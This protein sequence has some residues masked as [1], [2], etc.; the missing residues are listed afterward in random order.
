MKLPNVVTTLA[1]ACKTSGGTAWVV[2]GQVRDSLIGLDS[3]DIDIEVHGIE[4]EA[5]HEL[6]AKLGPVNE[7][8]KSFGVFKV[9]IE[10]VPMDVSIPRRDSQVGLR[11][12][13]VSVSGDPHMGIEE[14]ARRR[15][16]T[17]NAIAYDP[18]TGEYADPY[19]GIH[20][21]ERGR[22]TA[23]DPSTFMEDPLRALRVVQFAARFGFSIHEDLM[24]LCRSTRLTTLPA[25]RIWGEIEKLLMRSPAPSIG[26]EA[27]MHTGTLAQVLPE[28]AG[29][30]REVVEAALDRAA[31]LRADLDEPGRATALMVAALLHR[32]TAKAAVASLDRLKLYRLHDYPVRTRVLEAIEHWRALAGKRTDP[33]ILALA[34]QT[35]ILLVASVAWA[36]TGR[37]EALG[38]IDRAY[39]LGVSQTPLPPLLQG[40]DLT[41][42]GVE[43]G[44]ELGALLDRLRIAQLAGEVQDKDA[45]LTWIQ[46]QLE[47]DG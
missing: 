9:V 23:V 39:R 2:G 38:N 40:R 34:D 26:W 24:D 3:K 42:V 31:E 4:A 41:A 19:A 6:L 25:E 5:L 1:E 21:I 29:Q 44:P 32:T 13:D 37:H 27:G 10:E 47:K 12:K 22:L 30:P 16:L 17:I 8:G 7:I 11:H 43:P 15:D 33:E 28:A 46:A 45:A 14:A 20:D 18:L 36:A 35:E